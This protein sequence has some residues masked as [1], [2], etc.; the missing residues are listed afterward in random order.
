[1]TPKYSVLTYNVGGYEKIHEIKEKSP[2]AE[3]IYVTDD[4][5]LK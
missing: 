5:T 4:P 1:M 2:N 3:Y